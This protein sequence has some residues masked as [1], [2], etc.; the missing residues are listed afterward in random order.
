MSVSTDGSCAAAASNE[1]EWPQ[2]QP[3]LTPVQ[4]LVLKLLE[5]KGQNASLPLEHDKLPFFFIDSK[6]IMDLCTSENWLSISIIQLWC[7]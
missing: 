7:T 2:E 3:Q 6:E 5:F 1:K 4:K